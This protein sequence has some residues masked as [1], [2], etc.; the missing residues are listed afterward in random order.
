MRT[1]RPYSGKRSLLRFLLPLLLVVAAAIVI[2]LFAPKEPIPLPPGDPAAADPPVPADPAAPL[3]VLPDER[4][5]SGGERAV[6]PSDGGWQGASEDALRAFL[7][8]LSALPHYRPD[9]AARYL[10]YYGSERYDAREILRIV[11]TDNDLIPYEDAVPADTGKDI[12]MLVNKLHDLGDYEPDDLVPLGKYGTYGELR[13]EAYDAFTS[14]VDAAKEAGYTLTSNSPYRSA[15]LQQSVYNDY[16]HRNGTDEADTYSA[17]P[18]FSEHQTGLV[19]DVSVYGSDY[20]ELDGTPEHDWLCAHAHEYGFILRYGEGESHITG[21]IPEAWHF[22]YVG[23]D[24]AAYIYAHGITFE[25]YYY[26]YV[27][28]DDP[29]D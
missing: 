9:R 26:Y 16:A 28:G 25:E 22:R 23:V 27:I 24:A 13:R 5:E 15:R 10:N 20:G 2:S 21:Y 18:G 19:V 11:N 7:G 29:M 1:Y 12:L 4:V 14:L 8:E 3:P 6:A 17:R